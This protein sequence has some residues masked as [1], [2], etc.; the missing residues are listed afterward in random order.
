M[1]K[2]AVAS[3]QAFGTP[4]QMPAGGVAV[5]AAGA[6]AAAAAPDPALVQQG[7]Q[8]ATQ[9]TC[10]A[11]HTADG[12]AGAGP[13]WKGLFGSQVP[14]DNGQTV[15]G[16]EAYIRESILQPDAKTHKG[17]AKGVMAGTVTQFESQIQSGSNLDA[18]L[19]YIKSLK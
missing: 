11:C 9:F 13:T 17:F 3:G 4:N 1:N 16:D 14:L 8:L 19:A 10:V 5:S 7:Q 12:S 18:L 6:A 2:P 15:P